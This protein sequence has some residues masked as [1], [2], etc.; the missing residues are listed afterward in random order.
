M[1]QRD[2]DFFFFV[3]KVM[4]SE[5]KMITTTKTKRIIKPPKNPIAFNFV[6][7]IKQ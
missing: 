3:N 5:R 2:P 7:K 6:E 4:R 1:I